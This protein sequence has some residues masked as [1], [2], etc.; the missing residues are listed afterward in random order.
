M[1]PMLG[2]NTQRYPRHIVD[3]LRVQKAIS[4]NEGR[5]L[6]LMCNVFN[7]ANHQNIDGLGTTAYKLTT[8]GSTNTATWQGQY[9]STSNN[10]YQIP[11]SSNNSGF[12]FTPREIEIA[13]TFIF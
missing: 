7:V 11:T 10:T 12:L 8:S 9:S 3:D 2:P 13:G 6:E 1:L 5:S 4:F